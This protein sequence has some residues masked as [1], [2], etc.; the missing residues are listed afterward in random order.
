VGGEP[1]TPREKLAHIFRA[2]LL[3]HI[4]RVSVEDVPAE[5]TFPVVDDG[6]VLRMGDRRVQARYKG[7]QWVR[8]GGKPLTF[9][10]TLWLRLKPIGTGNA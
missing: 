3:K 7:G 6:T 10:P 2:E 4:E 8:L 5:G 9:E 1:V